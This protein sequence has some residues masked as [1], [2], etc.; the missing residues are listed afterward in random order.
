MDAPRTNRYR[1]TD[2][3]PHELPLPNCLSAFL[4]S[5]RSPS[6]QEAKTLTH[7]HPPLPVPLEGD[8]LRGHYEVIERVLND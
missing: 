6:F 4:R 7:P 3:L 1:S 8:E 5:S 2:S